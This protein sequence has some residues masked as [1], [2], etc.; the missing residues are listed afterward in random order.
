[1]TTLVTD[2]VSALSADQ[3]ILLPDFASC[4][5]VKALLHMNDLHYQVELRVNAESMSP[6]GKV[7]FLKVNSFLVSEF[8]PTVAFIRAKGH[9]LSDHLNKLE[10]AEM[11][12]YMALVDSVLINAELYFTWYDKVIW[13]EVT[14]PR[15]GALYS[16]PL[17]ILLP[18]KKQFEVNR[19]LSSI[20]WT[21]KTFPEVC[22]DV[23]TCCQALSETLG[24]HLYFFG[25]RPTELDALV[26]GHLY[27]LLTISLPV[28]RVAETVEQFSNLLNFCRRIDD[29][30]FKDKQRK[31]DN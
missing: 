29:T 9:S 24:D 25:D 26:F 16:W 27:S 10:Q 20:G 12:A 22:E 19:M 1:M 23:K 28:S 13:K 30:Y 4:L 8:D 5:S 31:W 14:K 17:N 2:A 15:H 11:R 21:R 6:T 3:Q 18:L 7:P